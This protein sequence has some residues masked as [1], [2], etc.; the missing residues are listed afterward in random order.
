[1]QIN[2][3]RLFN[4]LL[5]LGKFGLDESTNG[6]S[7][8]P[9]TEE[10]K[11]AK[12]FLTQ[13]M[14]QAGLEIYEDA[15]GNLFGKKLG[16]QP[17]LPAILIGS[18]IDTVKNGGK[19]DG[20]LGVLAGIEVL[21]TMFDTGFKPK[22]TI[23]VVAF[24]DEEGV[25]FSTGMLGSRAF[26]GQLP[27]D[28]LYRFTDKNGVTIAHSMEA[29]GLDPNKLKEAAFPTHQ[30]K[31]Y[32]ELHI[33]Q[34]NVLFTEDLPVGIVTGISG[35][36]WIQVSI[37]GEAGHA[38]TTPMHYRK[39][40]MPI[41]AELIT[42][43]T[44]EAAKLEATVATVG[45]INI[46]PG[47][48]NVIPNQVDLSFDIRSLEMKNI[49]LIEDVIKVFLQ[50]TC[51]RNQMTFEIE[52]LDELSPAICS[53]SIVNQIEHAARVHNLKPFKLISGAAHDAMVLSKVT[54]I[55]MIFVRSE[56]GIS[57]NPKEWTNKQ[58]IFQAT[59]V[60]YET[61]KNMAK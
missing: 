49:A 18:H 13:L 40:P 20:A 4:N 43:V 7:R 3:N 33:E 27:L 16:S 21:Q 28:E 15:I 11:Y 1:M 26:I 23:M 50:E 55:G 44:K 2:I 46:F 53:E 61:V 48:I 25:T 31:A 32:L 17:E 57:H 56:H 24:T 58:D 54:N 36:K 52:I 9:F 30:I 59:N 19:F 12:S 41:A 51:D 37:H 42:K 35:M 10:E 38:G 29:Y 22:H 47:N 39:D 34:G 60:L 45:K 5:E 6:V 14:K 8:F